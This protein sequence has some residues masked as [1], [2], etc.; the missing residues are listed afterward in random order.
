MV[1]ENKTTDTTFEY[2]HDQIKK[3]N[4]RVEKLE[5]FINNNKNNKNKKKP[6][7]PNA[8]KKNMSAFFHFAKEKREQFKKNNPD[9]KVYVVIINKKAKEEWD[10][11]DELQK[12]KY[13]ELADKDEKRYKKEI[14][15]Y[16]EKKELNK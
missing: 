7:D 5:K 11:L 16:N 15:K 13:I 1:K 9:A 12:K 8:P 2:L 14:K 4:L 6:K 3:L 10:V